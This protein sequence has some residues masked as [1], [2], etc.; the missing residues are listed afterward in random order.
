MIDIKLFTISGPVTLSIF[1]ISA[2]VLLLDTF[3]VGGMNQLFMSSGNVLTSF[4]SPMY[5]ASTVTYTF[6]H[7]NYGHFIG[8]MLLLL[9]LGPQIE[10]RVGSKFF[11]FSV[12][13]SSVAIAIAH[14]FLATGG[15]IGASGIVFMTITMSSFTANED[16]KI[17]ISFILVMLL[18][19]GQEVLNSFGADGVS[20]LAHIVGGVM[21]IFFGWR[22][23][24]GNKR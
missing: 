6:A 12:L 23:K 11:L 16:H 13:I 19:L 21:G 17:S 18:Y 3:M 9:L 14:G 5:W 10:Q 1:A 8:N 20:Q 4:L 7:A 2:V 24:I 15:L 22:Y